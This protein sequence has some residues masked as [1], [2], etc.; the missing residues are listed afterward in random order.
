MKPLLAHIY[1]P[2]RVDYASGVWLQDK[3]NGVRALS[4]DGFF[5]SRDELP[6]PPNMLEHLSVHMKQMFPPDWILDGELYVH[7][8]PLQRINQAIAVN[9]TVRGK[10]EDTQFVEYH[11]FDRVSYSQSFEER[12][13]KMRVEK[14]GLI[15]EKIPIKFVRSIKV[16]NEW[17]AND[18][19]TTA[20]GK[21]YEGIMYRIGNCPYTTAKQT[22]PT[23]GRRRFLADKNN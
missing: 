15:N 9:A 3:L 13:W 11:I 5:Q 23:K 22:G 8:W 6:W 19:Y 18:F 1:E 14:L 12:F 20:I 16:F 17:D 7:G 4:Q 10:N 2:H 21:K